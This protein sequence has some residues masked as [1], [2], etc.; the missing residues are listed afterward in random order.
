MAHSNHRGGRTTLASVNLGLVSGTVSLDSFAIGSPTGF[1][2]PQMFAVGKLAVDTGGVMR[3]RDE[4]IH[5]STIIID[6]PQLVI[7]QH[8]TKLNFKEL[9]DHLPSH[10]EQ[11]P[12][13]ATPSAPSKPVKF[14]ID[15]L[16]I[17]NAHVVLRSDIPGL[18]KPR[19][20]ALPTM[21]MQKIG[22]ADG[23]NNGAAIKDVVTTV[24]STMVAEATK[25][26][27]LPPE[28]TALLSGNLDSVQDKLTSDAQKQLDK[29]KIPVDVNGLL[30]QLGGNK[31]K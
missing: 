14:I 15:T 24:I 10:P 6:Q 12:P 22:N 29:K 5:I 11:S 17:T 20:L 16:S 9:M 8:G 23:A 30:N 28:I 18:D 31:S 19:D 21:T 26:K 4:P 25:D 13:Q 7:E 2:E 27:S 1:T 3:L